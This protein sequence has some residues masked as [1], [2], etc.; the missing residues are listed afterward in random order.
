MGYSFNAKSNDLSKVHTEHGAFLLTV[1][2][3]GTAELKD[4]KKRPR[5]L[6]NWIQ[7][8]VSNFKF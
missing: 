4:R 3:D 7:K 6:R 8:L 5:F 1:K 2:S